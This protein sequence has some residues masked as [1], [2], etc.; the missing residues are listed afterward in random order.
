MRIRSPVIPKE[1]Q[2]EERLKEPY[3]CDGQDCHL[4]GKCWHLLFLKTGEP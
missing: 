3:T 2:V 1:A 4:K